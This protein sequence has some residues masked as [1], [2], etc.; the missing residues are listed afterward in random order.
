MAAILDV[1]ERGCWSSASEAPGDLRALL[2]RKLG[3]HEGRGGDLLVGAGPTSSVQEGGPLSRRAHRAGVGVR[4]HQLQ[5][6]RGGPVVEG[7][8]PGAVAAHPDAHGPQQHGHARHRPFS[9]G[10]H[11]DVVVG[12]CLRNSYKKKKEK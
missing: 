10:G 5:H 3:P 8:L 1:R 7:Q 4:A 2:L 9:R 6:A 12:L 11:G